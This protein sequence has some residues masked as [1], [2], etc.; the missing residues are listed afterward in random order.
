[1]IINHNNVFTMSINMLQLVAVAVGVS[2]EQASTMKQSKL[3]S[4][5]AKKLYDSVTLGA[6]Y[7]ADTL[8]H[9]MLCSAELNAYI[10]NAQANTAQADADAKAQAG[11]NAERSAQAE[12]ERAEAER[13]ERMAKAEAEAT[14]PNDAA[15]RQQRANATSCKQWLIDLLGAVGAKYTLKQLCQLTGKSEVNVRTMLSD[16]RSA[17]YAGKYGVFNTKSVRIDGVTWYSKA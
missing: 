14:A 6:A 12:A 15:Q 10:D 9:A 13:A 3:R 2:A 5:V 1:M 8:D 17:R 11:A 16:L 4:M 7:Q